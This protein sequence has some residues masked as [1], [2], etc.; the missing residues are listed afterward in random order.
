MGSVLDEPTARLLT[1]VDFLVLASDTIQS[2]RVFNAIVHQY[3]IPGV[4]I[5]A[6]VLVDQKTHRVGDIFVATRP[7]HPR[8]E[9]GLPSLPRAHPAR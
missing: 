3:L 6:Q 9:F 1:D 8:P 2:R 7:V 4:Q 5:G